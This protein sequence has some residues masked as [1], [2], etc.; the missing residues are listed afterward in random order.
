MYVYI[1]NNLFLQITEKRTLLQIHEADGK[2]YKIVDTYVENV[3][4][5]QEDFKSD[6]FPLYAK[7][8]A[9]VTDAVEE[10][11]TSIEQKSCRAQVTN[12]LN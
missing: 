1:L 2:V 5:T 8:N 3:K 11:K 10:C 7:V 12:N 9:E 6:I 4:H